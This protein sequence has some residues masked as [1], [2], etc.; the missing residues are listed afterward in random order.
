MR[1]YK[2]IKINIYL[3][4][5]IALDIRMSVSTIRKLMKSTYRWTFMIIMKAVAFVKIVSITLRAST[6]TGASLNFTDL[7]T[8]YSM[9][10]TYVNV[11]HPEY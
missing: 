1:I 3:Q 11:S 5:A 7:V 10:L 2:Y 4:L 8:N 9:R 6:A